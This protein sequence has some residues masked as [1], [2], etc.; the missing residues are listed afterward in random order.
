M[1]YP[2]NPLFCTQSANK[3]SPL[4]IFGENKPGNRQL[5]RRLAK[6][7]TFATNK[8]WNLNKKI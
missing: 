2:L 7:L 1:H 4:P 8:A 5:R 3:E 6:L